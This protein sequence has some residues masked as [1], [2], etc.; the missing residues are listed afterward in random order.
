M[1]SPI[2]HTLLTLALAALALNLSVIHEAQ[3]ASWDYTGSMK[4]ARYGHTATLLL[5]GKVLVAGGYDG[6]N[7]LNSAELYDPAS[8]T[9]TSTGSLQYPRWYHTATLLPNGK[10]LVAGGFAGNI[11]YFDRLPGPYREYELYDPATG[12]WTSPGETTFGRCGHTA[13]LLPDGNVLVQGGLTNGYTEIYLTSSGNWSLV[14][15][16]IQDSPANDTA[17]L[18]TNGL[19]LQAGGYDT[20]D[21]SPKGLEEFYPN[22]GS[23]GGYWNLWY[24]PREHHTAT[25]L[26]NG[27]VLVA[28]GIW[29][30]MNAEVF[31]RSTGSSSL[32]GPMQQLRENHTATLL[33]NGQVLVAG[34][35]QPNGLN[36][37][38]LAYAEVYDPST[39]NWTATNSMNDPRAYHTA[40]MLPN[41]KVLVVGGTYDGVHPRATAEL[42]DPSI[43]PATGTWAAANSLNNAREEHTATL[44]PNG[45]VLVAGGYGSSGYLSSAEVYELIVLPGRSYWG[46]KLTG[47]LNNE[48]AYHTATLLTNGKVLVAG[49]ATDYVTYGDAQLYD[50]ATG[51]WTA[52]GSMTA[53]SSSHTATLLPNGKVLVAGGEDN[54]GNRLSRAELYDPA[55]G[56]WTATGSMNNARAGHTATLLSNGKV[57]VAGGYGSSGLL[58]SAEL[59]DPATGAWT[60]TGSMNNIR[61]NHTATLLP[62]GNVLVA[63]GYN[64]GGS[65]SSA[66]YYNPSIGVWKTTGSLAT[67]RAYHTATLLPNG[68]VLVAGG[69]GSSLF[70]SA[71]LYDVG[72][73]FSASWQ[74]LI[75][76]CTSPLNL[77]SSLTLTGWKFRGIS[78]GSGG[79]SCQDSPADYPLVQLRSLA[80][81]QT[82]FLNSTNWSTNSV[83][84]GIVTN[85]PPGYAMATVFVNGIP[86]TGSILNIMNST[87]MDFRITS[88]SKQGNDILITWLTLGGTTNVV[89]ATS[90]LAGGGSSSG[91][92][93]LSPQIVASGTGQTV[94]NYLDVGGANGIGVWAAAGSMNTVRLN[95]TGTLLPNGKVLVA[96]G[97]GSGNVYLSSAELYDP[98]T[99]TWTATGSMNTARA[100]HTATL[101]PNG[102]VLVAGGNGSGGVLASAELYD[103]ASGTWTTTGSMATARFEHMTVLLANGQVLVVGGEG[104][105]SDLASAELYNPATGTWSPTGSLNTARWFHTATLLANGKVLVAAGYHNSVSLV[106]AELY[107]PA[108]GTWT[109]TGSMNAARYYH[110]ATLL[111]NGKVLVSGGTVTPGGP[112]LTSAELY[113]PASGTWTTTGSM[114]GTRCW[115]TSTLL[116]SGQVLVV[117]GYNGGRSSGAELYNP[118]SGTWTATGSL[119]TGRDAQSAT[120]LPNGR[121]LV[122]GGIGYSGNL[123]SAELYDAK[124]TRFYRVRLVQP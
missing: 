42:Y 55:S 12:S 11:A 91:F 45:T 17:T 56:T 27:L 47:P 107:D 6:T 22:T 49:G 116:P 68:N 77:G 31:N 14:Y 105:S 53:A 59:Y 24:Y 74:P 38:F 103:P 1:K 101:L 46:W 109:A 8:G 63:G 120:M 16:E 115:H 41:G 123:A 19:V 86:S 35:W 117:G 10:V 20:I 95:Q 72:L 76:T 9:W 108:T 104:S 114:A 23:W 119:A 58:S 39:G 106:S 96:G 70:S 100:E 52:T 94:T 28:G 113:D 2:Q 54:S 88:I 112:F 61:A 26:A 79:N 71:E 85:F 32:T 93:D 124:T 4:A 81:D 33:P 64:S 110:R 78:E 75:S 69:Y 3:A 13:T 66:E 67:A 122:A 84:T 50:P 82:V 62:N 34:G 111:P 44:L 60:A 25:L 29:S 90:A 73:G 48:R 118:A 98:A 83:T 57:L 7:T 21:K 36:A 65:L 18:Q 15:D 37:Q 80:N 97:Y 43:S 5:N 30:Q 102:K 92:A 121:V 87:I 89:Q 99:G 40:T 51:T